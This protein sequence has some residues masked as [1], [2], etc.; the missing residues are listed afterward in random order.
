MYRESNYTVCA[1]CGSSLALDRAEL[2]GE[3]RFVC[4]MCAARARFDQALVRWR[5]DRR[6]RYLPR[7]A[8][9]L[10]IVTLALMFPTVVVSGIIIGVVVYFGTAPHR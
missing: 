6:E 2:D 8:L 1:G 5:A 10:G 4:H 9:G 7:V 3:A